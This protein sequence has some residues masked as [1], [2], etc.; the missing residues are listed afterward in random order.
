MGHSV[1]KSQQ[2][3]HFVCS[4][5]FVN[6]KGS[7][8]FLKIMVDFQDSMYLILGQWLNGFKLL[9]ITYLVGKIKFIFLFQGPLAK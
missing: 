7:T 4:K 2:N 9:G 6:Q 8:F 5:D 1:S 3:R